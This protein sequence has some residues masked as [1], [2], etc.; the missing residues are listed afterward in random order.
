MQIRS[1]VAAT[2]PA[3]ASAAMDH[4]RGRLSYE[5][6]CADVAADQAAGLAGFV[7]VDCRSPESYAQGHLPG[8]I[9]LPHRRI[10][11]A[12]VDELIPDESTLVIT[13][14][15]GPS[16]NASTKGALRFAALGRPVKEMPGGIDGWV[17]E[18]LPVEHGPDNRVGAR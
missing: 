10:T 8:A 9:N 13:Y 11:A 2:A 16:C 12:A 3:T 4:F 14:C 6:D 18:H 5:V 15:A 7:V 1:A 17:R